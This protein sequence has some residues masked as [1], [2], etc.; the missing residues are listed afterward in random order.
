MT[1]G[2]RWYS[3]R[4]PGFLGSVVAHGANASVSCVWPEFLPPGCLETY[5]YLEVG[6]QTSFTDS[7]LL[8]LGLPPFQRCPVSKP[9]MG[10]QHR[11]Q[12]PVTTWQATP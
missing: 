11:A 3:S 7:H 6:L 8:N 2:L 5:T 9:N 4:G 10:H 12:D 1:W